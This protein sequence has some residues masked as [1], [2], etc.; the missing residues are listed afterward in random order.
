MGERRTAVIIGV[1]IAVIVG[2]LLVWAFAFNNAPSTANLTEITD[3][4]ALKK[5]AQ[6][7]QVGIATGENY[8]GHR[9]R[10]IHGTITN[11]SDKPLRMVDVNMTFNDYDAK[12]VQRSVQRVFEAT[13]K[14]LPPAAKYRFEV[15]FENL[16]RTWNYHIPDIEVVKIAY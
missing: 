8:M 15:N 7:S 1:T 3:K 4:P 16:P 13:Q 6:I 9:I 12:P 5:I 10:V 14:P 11:N 2:V